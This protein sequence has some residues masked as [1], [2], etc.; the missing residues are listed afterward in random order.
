MSDIIK[1]LT[2]LVESFFQII[3][4]TISAVVNTIVSTLQAAFAFIVS[5]VQGAFN[6]SEGVVGLILGKFP[7]HHPSFQYSPPN[8][9]G[10]NG[11]TFQ[12]T[13]P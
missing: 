13:S 6:I 5:I 1:G 7:L 2:N 9:V 4:G 3:Y 10:T 12:A 8:P 11:A